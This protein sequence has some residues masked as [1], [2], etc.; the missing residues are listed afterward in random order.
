[1]YS[2]IHVVKIH[3]RS[4]IFNQQMGLINY[5]SLLFTKKKTRLI[6]HNLYGFVFLSEL[7]CMNTIIHFQTFNVLGCYVHFIE[8]RNWNFRVDCVK[9]MNLIEIESL[10]RCSAQSFN[11]KL[12]VFIS[13]ITLFISIIRFKNQIKTKFWYKLPFLLK[14]HKS[15]ILYFFHINSIFIHQQ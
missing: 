15:K 8:S 2:P 6:F 3:N 5:Q 11:F 9:N 1:M 7:E 10:L 13:W 14:K 4:S 12:I